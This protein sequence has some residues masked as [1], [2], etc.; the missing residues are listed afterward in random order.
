MT[1]ESEMRKP[2]KIAIAEMKC[3]CTKRNLRSNNLIALEL[4]RIVSALLDQGAHSIKIRWVDEEK[5]FLIDA[6]R[7]A[8]EWIDL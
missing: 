3:I 7:M 4:N 5:Y 8:R 2:S 6:V 1:K